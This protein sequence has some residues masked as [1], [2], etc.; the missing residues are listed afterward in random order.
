MARIVS[1]LYVSGVCCLSV[2]RVVYDALVRC[3]SQANYVL[4]GLLS[5]LLNDLLHTTRLLLPRFIAYRNPLMCGSVLEG[6]IALGLSPAHVNVAVRIVEKL[7]L[8]APPG[9]LGYGRSR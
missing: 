4:E 1:A 9:S 2:Q 3:G 6:G 5:Y 8:P 7:A